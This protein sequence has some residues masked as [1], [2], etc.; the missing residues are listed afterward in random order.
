[1]PTTKKTQARELVLCEQRKERLQS[2]SPIPSQKRYLPMLTDFTALFPH[3]G[4]NAFSAIKSIEINN[5][6]LSEV[7]IQKLRTRK[8]WWWCVLF[9][10]VMIAFRQQ[11]QVPLTMFLFASGAYCRVQRRRLSWKNAMRSRP[12]NSMRS[13]TFGSL[14]TA[15]S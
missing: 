12:I 11:L 5:K 2:S 8:S 1:M 4:N 14:T 3:A 9:K 7:N 6:S 13:A 10:N 15:N